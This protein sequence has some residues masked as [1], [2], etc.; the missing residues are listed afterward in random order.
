M[1]EYIENDIEDARWVF[2]ITVWFNPN[3]FLLNLR[4][5]NV[6]EIEISYSY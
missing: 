5:E 2:F 4:V 1:P 6:E 3:T